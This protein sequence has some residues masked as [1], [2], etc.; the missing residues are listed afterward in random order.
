MD[1]T[2][3]TQPI[4]RLTY[5]LHFEVHP[6]ADADALGIEIEDLCN[7]TDWHQAQ[8]VDYCD[9]SWESAAAPVIEARPAPLP[10]TDLADWADSI[11]YLMLNGNRS[12][13]RLAFQALD[14]QAARVAL[15]VVR[16]LVKHDSSS[17]PAT[18]WADA[19]VNVQS[20]LGECF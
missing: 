9:V 17:Q 7:D 1:N 4:R 3:P 11:A 6:D 20:L 15:A 19:V 13:A 10:D 14:T 18:C 5:T 12:D 2:T 16:R 8:D